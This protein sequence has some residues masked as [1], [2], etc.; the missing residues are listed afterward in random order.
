MRKWLGDEMIPFYKSLDE[1]RKKFTKTTE[2]VES[3]NQHQFP[4]A[5]F[6]VAGIDDEYN[7]KTLTMF[8][9]IGKN[10]SFLWVWVGGDLDEDDT[11]I[12]EYCEI[13][14][15]DVQKYHPEY[16][17]AVSSYVP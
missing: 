14:I 13:P 17:K 1:F 3:E 15:D 8:F 11:F 4:H 2:S 12:D 10:D 9:H 6:I 16:F 7:G 5:K